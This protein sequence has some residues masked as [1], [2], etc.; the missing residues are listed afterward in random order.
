MNKKVTKTNS[1]TV[2]PNP[3][4]QSSSSYYT[5]TS[6]IPQKDPLFV[7]Y[8][9]YEATKRIIAS[10]LFH[11]TW[12]SGPKGVG[13]TLQVQEACA[14]LNREFILLA[15]TEQTDEEDLIGGLRLENG[16]TVWQDGPVV[17]AMRRGSI[18]LLDE[19]DKGG[20]KMMTLQNILNGGGH[21]I[22][23]DN[24]YI[25]PTD[26]FNIF[27][28]ANTK[29]KG[30]DTGKYITSNVMDDA[31]FGRFSEMY[32]VDFPPEHIYE[33]IGVKLFKHFGF[34]LKSL[35]IK[36]LLSNLVKWIVKTNQTYTE[37]GIEEAID[38]R[39]LKHV[40]RAY[41]IHNQ[42]RKLALQGYCSKFD[43]DTK[44]AM[45]SFYSKIDEHFY[46]LP[47][48][49][50]DCDSILP[51]LQKQT[52]VKK[53]YK[54]TLNKLFTNDPKLPTSK[55]KKAFERKTINGIPLANF[56]ETDFN[57]LQPF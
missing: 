24:R 42:N 8:G 11:P 4:E 18:L 41:K 26:G 40:I 43:A 20:P 1:I 46:S 51:I 36:N 53:A 21:F 19:T 12:L 28:T 14:E 27:A 13:K 2:M 49:K 55:G 3:T 50:S 29:G 44:S 9:S 17:E 54:E 15:I 25:T 45:L 33:A 48:D 16:C 5:S 35:E 39:A 22:K 34:D 7:P 30:D 56:D 57:K 6:L 52:E 23:K 31:F 38:T 32:N 37:G 10:R 47:E